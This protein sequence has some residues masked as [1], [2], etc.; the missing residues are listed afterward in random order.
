MNKL[1]GLRDKSVE[2]RRMVDYKKGKIYEIVCRKTGGRYIGSTIESLAKRLAKHRRMK[3]GCS[4]ISIIEGGDYYINL[5]ESYPCD[6]KELLLQKEREWYEKGNC[7]NKRRPITT[8]EEDRLQNKNRN[9]TDEYR[10]K[11]AE[12]KREWRLKN[13]TDEVKKKIAEEL[14]IK[15][16]TDEYRKKHAE[17]A[18]I[19]RLK[20]KEKDE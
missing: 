6:T 11:H 9:N 3:D 12:W 14:A 15:R 1:N 8:I 4:S 5:L 18:R 2:K 16:N 19:W 17:N 13:E 7:V 20:Q 10:K